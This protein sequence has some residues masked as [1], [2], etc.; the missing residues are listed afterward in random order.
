MYNNLINCF[1]EGVSS[2]QGRQ[3]YFFMFKT[4]IAHSIWV[5]INIYCPLK[6][7]Y[8]RICISV[9]IHSLLGHVFMI[10]CARM[11]VYV[12][13]HNVLFVHVTKLRA[14]THLCM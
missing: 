4:T 1:G 12:H 7:K 5:F 14:H 10:Q 2:N 11:Y 9:S 6:L 13:V 3:L 8:A